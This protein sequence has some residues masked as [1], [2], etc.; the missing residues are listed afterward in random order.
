MV[1]FFI[2]LPLLV[3]LSGIIWWLRRAHPDNQSFYYFR[4][5]L[6]IWSVCTVAI[7]A[8]ET[9]FGTAYAKSMALSVAVPF[10]YVAS[11]YLVV[12][13]FSLY[14]KRGALSRFLA[15]LV[16]VAGILFGATTFVTANKLIPSLGLLQDLFAHLSANLTLYRIWSTLAIFVPIGIFFFYEAAKYREMRSRIRSVLI[17]S[18][19]IIAG[20]SEYFHILAKHHAGADF[21]TVLGFLLVTAGLLYPLWKPSMPQAA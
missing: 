8:A 2:L 5:F 18:G 10:L 17:G 12:L 4:N 13:P 15:I 6:M 21:Y 3:I 9:F 20:V 11:A 1:H 19:L 7:G 14:E 16:I